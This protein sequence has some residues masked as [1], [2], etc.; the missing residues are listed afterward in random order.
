MSSQL[1]FQKKASPLL[2]LH[3]KKSSQM[4]PCS[5]CFHKC[6]F[7]RNKRDARAN[8]TIPAHTDIKRIRLLSIIYIQQLQTL[9]LCRREKVSLF[10]PAHLIKVYLS[11]L[12]I[13]YIILNQQQVLELCRSKQVSIFYTFMDIFIL[14]T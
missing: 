3:Y 4:I 1:N 14:Y 9:E 2:L 7:S 13:N 6:P 12:Y 8:S 10:Y 5:T 11:L